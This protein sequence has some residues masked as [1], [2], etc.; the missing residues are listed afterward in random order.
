MHQI[1]DSHR[2]RYVTSTKKE[3]HGLVKRILAE[4]KEGGARFLKR[5]NTDSS[6]WI[7][8]DDDCAYLKISHALRCKRRKAQEAP[9]LQELPI[10][11]RPTQAENAQAENA[12]AEN[13]Q[14]E[15]AQANTSA[16]SSAL[17]LLAPNSAFGALS[18]LLCPSRSVVPRDSG[19]LLQEQ[20]MA[21]QTLQSLGHT[22]GF[23]PTADLLLLSSPTQLDTN[24][25]LRTMEQVMLREELRRRY[26]PWL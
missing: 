9:T 8:V 10:D 21:L 14:A 6:A 26:Y 13:A 18:S 19:L 3:K 25:A 11:S 1:V 15:N 23:G 2:G 24:I 17:H 12:Q 20:I 4:V 22:T 5:S 7:Q 16:T